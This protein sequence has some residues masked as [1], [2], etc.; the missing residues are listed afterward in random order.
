[1]TDNDAET[2]ATAIDPV[3]GMTVKLGIG[4]PTLNYNGTD[5]HFCNPR[6]HTRF[7]ADPVFFLSGRSKLKKKSAPKAA[8]YICPMDPEV[9]SDKPGDCPICGMALE[10]DAPVGSVPAANPE[11][12][13][14]TRR[15][16]I[17]LT[18]AA[19]LLILAMGHMA[20]LPFRHMLGER[21]SQFVELALA[22][23]VVLWAA[24]PFFRRG[25]ASIRN[26]HANMWTLISLGVSA[27]FVYSCVAVLAPWVFPAELR[28][29]DGTVP[30]YFEASAVI[31]ALV[32][33]GQVLELKAREKTSAALAEILALAPKTAMRIND[34][35][36]EY[37]APVENLLPG[38]RIRIR[39]G[40]AVPV[41]GTVLEGN[42]TLDE[43]MI[44]GEPLP[45]ERS[46]GGE[47]TAGTLSAGQA[48]VM[49]ATKVGDETVLAAIGEMVIQAQRSRAPL[50]KLADKVSAWFVP[51]VVL[52]ALAAFFGW[53]VFDPGSGLGAGLGNAVIA[54]VSVLII[55]CPCALGLATP[56]SVTNAVARGARAGVLV[57]EASALERLAACDVLIVD[58]T[59]TL[60]EGRPS[61]SSIS[62]FDGWSENDALAVAASL[63]MNSAHPLAKAILGAAAAK[64]I[65]VAPAQSVETI[66]GK[67]V[68]G[69]TTK[70]IA[71]L[72]NAALMQDN[73]VETAKFATET[74]IPSSQMYLAVAG[75]PV[76]LFLASDAI[77]PG[78]RETV[79]QLQASGLSVV[80][81]T[82]DNEGS[83]R[84]VA[85]EV[86]ISQVFFAM[87]PGGK[88]DLIVNL[89]KEGKTVAFAGDGINDSPALAAAD[90]GLAFASGSAVAMETAGI[91]L[92][93]PDVAAILRARRL[94]TAT[95]RN[96][97][98]NL[99][100]AFA[101][102]GIGIPVAAGLFYPV[103]G[104]LLSP[105]VAAAAM[106]LSSVSV[107]ANALRLRN[108]KL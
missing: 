55:A 99:W 12:V 106:S 9:L 51:L 17:S 94:A 70:G 45:V 93:K 41:D 42:A 78:A 32:F 11:L 35:G 1:M 25:I 89:K 83:A 19:P 43:S 62:T 16:W 92:I 49:K 97:K 27:A 84:A 56:M 88:H 63:Q 48:F 50:Q 98:Q 85:K 107:I 15:F 8:R 74:Q 38:D 21:L 86:G 54:A 77:K 96:I 58:K 100:F 72:G 18:L 79:R 73:A 105:M 71:I 104:I 3:C 22:A 59:G 66:H 64:G 57:R 68:Q 31:V 6:C 29:P 52:S 2:T 23:P 5:Y 20:G 75:K 13:D 26:R 40:D 33:L 28:S 95:V 24:L 103:W 60:T 61:L 65:E 76:A 67:G 102:N 46:M 90:C 69:T 39:A 53:L 7:G 108:V 82:G 80:M 81:A 34:D 91:T 47:V 101:Y 36:S 87:L 4:K 10:A 30:V 14:F 44:T 37:E